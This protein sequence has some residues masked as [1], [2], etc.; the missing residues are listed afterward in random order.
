MR[1]NIFHVYLPFA[2]YAFTSF[3][4]VLV[5]FLMNLNELY[6]LKKIKHFF[7]IYIVNYFYQIFILL[8]NLL[9]DVLHFS[10][11][12]IFFV[13]AVISFLFNLKDS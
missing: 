6:L 3:V 8:H 9:L 13:P 4:S 5:I 2:N 12:E 7:V 11:I 1:L 10:I